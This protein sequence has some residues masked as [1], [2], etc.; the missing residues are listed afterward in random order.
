[1][2][3][4]K[5]SR[6]RRQR[7]ASPKGRQ[8]SDRPKNVWH[9]KGPQVAYGRERFR[10]WAL[11]GGQRGRLLIDDLVEGFSWR[12]ESA[13]LTGDVQLRDPAYLKKELGVGT[14]DQILVEVAGGP[15]G[16]FREL[17]RMRIGQPT[18]NYGDGSRTY[19]MADDMS[20][21]AA[22]EDDWRFARDR[23]H[24]K[25]WLGH[26]VIRYVCRRYGVQVG[27]IPRM[28][29]RIKKLVKTNTSPLDIILHV[30]LTAK[31]ESGRRY[32]VRM[33]KG[34]LYVEPLRRSRLLLEMGPTI[35]EASLRE[36]MREGFATA[37]T[38]RGG[39]VR[40]AGADGRGH[41]R[42][43]RRKI[44]VRVRSPKGIKRYGLVHRIVFSVESE[45][46]AHARARARRYIARMAKPSRELSVTHPG[47]PFIRRLHALRINLP[48]AALRQI[49]FVSSATH[50]VGPGGYQSEL[51]LSMDDPFVDKRAQD[52]TE[53]RQQ[54]AA[55]RTNRKKPKRTA[56]KKKKAQPKRNEQ[57]RPKPKPALPTGK[58]LSE[59]FQR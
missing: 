15:N 58:D 33:Y 13:I 34:K 2:A 14:G 29:V 17:W 31:R 36:T 3:A 44:S 21:L 23:R 19:V 22:S 6:A 41:R 1:V 52:V 59:E 54:K 39:T 50:T 55:T 25:G 43:T 18:R 16:A 4:R 35:A 8:R 47:L 42:K 40:D 26:E 5:A 48:D 56:P 7:R 37:V 49:V 45:S 27:R 32:T 28:T 12:D 20:L 57:R 51:T 38:L 30:L 9:R 46:L 10:C 11:R 24:R 53:E